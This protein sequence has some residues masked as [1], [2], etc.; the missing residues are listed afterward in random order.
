M[1]QLKTT[2]LGWAVILLPIL[3]H[4][5]SNNK[6]IAENDKTYAAITVKDCSTG[7]FYNRVTS[8]AKLPYCNYKDSIMSKQLFKQAYFE[9]Y[10]ASY[11]NLKSNKGVS[12]GFLDSAI[13][14]YSIQNTLMLGVINAQFNYIDSNYLQPKFFKTEKG[15]RVWQMPNKHKLQEQNIVLATILQEKPVSGTVK[16]FMPNYMQLGNANES[17]AFITIT[18]KNGNIY[19][20]KPGEQ[21]DISIPALNTILIFIEIEFTN[22]KKSIMQSCIDGLEP[23]NQSYRS[24]GLLPQG[25]YTPTSNFVSNALS[26]NSDCIFQGYDETQPY[27]G[28]ILPTYYYRNGIPCDGRIQNLQNP[29]ILLDGFDPLCTRKPLEMYTDFFNYSSITGPKNMCDQLTSQGYDVIVI[30]MPAYYEGTDTDQF[31]NTKPRLV[32]GG[33]DYIERNALNLVAYLRW[34][35]TQIPAGQ[36]IALVGPSMGGQISRYALNYME[37]RGEQHNVRLWISMDSPHKGANIPIGAQTL[38]E[39]L[40]LVNDEANVF[41]ER[42]LN[43]PAAKQQL[44]HHFT[45]QSEKPMGAPGFFT[46]YYAAQNAMGWP[47][48]CRKVAM[49]SGAVDG[50]LHLNGIGCNNAFDA[51]IN[52]NIFGLFQITIATMRGF[53]A[54]NGINNRCLTSRLFTTDKI[55]WSHILTTHVSEH[56]AY[57]FEKS[58]TSIDLMPGGQF[59]AFG[60]MAASFGASQNLPG[61]FILNN[62]KN[63]HSFIPTY[64]AIAGSDNNQIKWDDDLRQYMYRCQNISPFD[65]FMGPTGKNYKHDELFEAQANEIIEEINGIKHYFP[66]PTER[67]T[68]NDNS[69]LN[70][71]PQIVK[72]FSVYPQSMGSCNWVLN[73]SLFQIVNG[74]GTNTISI[75]YNGGGPSQV[76]LPLSVSIDGYC[77]NYSGDLQ[78][79]I[80]PVFNLGDINNVTRVYRGTYIPS[81]TGPYGNFQPNAI[82]SL[83]S[84]NIFIEIGNRFVQQS[85]VIFSLINSVGL[86]NG[87]TQYT[88]S[89]GNKQLA[90]SG[91]TNTPNQHFFNVRYNHVCAGPQSEN[92]SVK[93]I[94]SKLGRFVDYSR[95]NNFVYINLESSKSNIDFPS[96]SKVSEKYKVEWYDLSGKLLL[97]EFAFENGDRLKIK[98][99]SIPKGIYITKV[100]NGFVNQ[101]IKIVL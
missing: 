22:G 15:K 7:I 78:S 54:P 14:A 26:Y 74:Q 48:Q 92:F 18:F 39:D 42:F 69:N 25:C 96:K 59:D 53:F 91:N 58:N 97:N 51:D 23:N 72:S 3:M 45:A 62:L 55:D 6:I 77:T 5:Q 99:P 70:W 33:G 4:A 32:M 94:A 85:T 24:N 19:K 28:Q 88:T 95:D 2:L 52:Q 43:A 21:I 87:W 46:R 1:K 31:G 64:S 98:I 41:K 49:V 80:H 10:H 13:T 17:V 63:F 86:L 73:S 9:L 36:T 66:K 60:I 27:A 11:D 30:D 101:S 89:N 37:K 50:T 75:K 93:F 81:S 71:C 12:P 65:Y 44:I 100:Y 56:Y 40:A 84:P 76:E 67:I 90:A 47:T 68:I 16:V 29:V 8:F 57:G 35:K 82:I 34:L 83:R 79:Q 61:W 20:I 38:L